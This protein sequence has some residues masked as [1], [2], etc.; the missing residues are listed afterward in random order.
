MLL[1]GLPIKLG[2][3]LVPSSPTVRLVYL[4]E[5]SIPPVAITG[6]PSQGREQI[7]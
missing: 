5:T 4:S 6:I 7:H 1:I 2:V 3:G